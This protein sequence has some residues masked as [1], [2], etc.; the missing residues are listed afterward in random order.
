MSTDDFFNVPEIAVEDP[1]RNEVEVLVLQT[2]KAAIA[3]IDMLNEQHCPRPDLSLNP[4]LQIEIDLWTQRISAMRYHAGNMALVTLVYLFQNWR[5]RNGSPK[6]PS[7]EF[8]ERWQEITDARDSIIHHN[9]KPEFDNPYQKQKHRTVIDQFL[10]FN[11]A[12][13]ERVAIDWSTLKAVARE[14]TSWEACLGGKRPS[15]K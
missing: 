1:F 6:L 12:G 13:E 11:D 3:G 9:G 8:I 7:C 2:Y 5:H 4:E 15:T 10:N 14:L